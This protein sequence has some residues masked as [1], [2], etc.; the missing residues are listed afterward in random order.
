MVKYA[1]DYVTC[2]K[3]IF[4]KYFTFDASIGTISGTGD[5][6]VNEI[7]PDTPCG[8]C[9]NCTRHKND[10]ASQLVYED[11]TLEAA[12][13]ARLCRALKERGEKA[14]MAKLIQLWQGRGLKAAKIETV[15]KNDPD[16]EV[17]ANKKYSTQVWK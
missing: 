14:T 16:V 12:T 4:E 9:D 17:P 7:T 3:I 1:Q 5:K 15:I 8:I 13:L 6:L 2:R 10:P 11:V